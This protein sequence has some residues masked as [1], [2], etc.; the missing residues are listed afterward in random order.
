MNAVRVLCLLIVLVFTTQFSG[1]ATPAQ[2]LDVRAVELGY[3]RLVVQGEGY[4]HAVYLKEVPGADTKELHV[5]LEGDGTPWMRRRV[6]AF[7]PTPRN[8]LMFD[9]MMLDPAPSVYLGRPCY[10]GIRS[11]ACT[12]QMWTD[13]RYSEAVVASMSTALDNV[14]AQYQSLVLLGYSGGGPLAMLLAGRQPKVT[15]VVTVA[16][17]LDTDRWAALHKQQ[18]LSES[19]NPALR[20]PLRPE[21]RQM[22]YAGERDDNV[23]PGLVRDAIGRQRAAAF[24]VYPKQDHS[25]CWREVWPEVLGALAAK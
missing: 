13:K 2:R 18:S 10:H 16:A 15:A 11:A 14:S 3:R 7:D 17:N 6:P 12:P 1:C 19:L 22:H 5:Y 9:L 25:C 20:P 24:K 21:I 4:S 23:P 8:P